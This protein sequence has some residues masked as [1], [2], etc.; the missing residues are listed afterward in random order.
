[1]FIDP[2]L[3]KIN[4]KIF[5]DNYDR[6]REDY[7]KLRD[8]VF[9]FDYSHKYDFPSIDEKSPVRE[10]LTRISANQN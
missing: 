8:S 1:M 2:K 9:F 3:S 6:I 10:A 5:T 7:I 4:T